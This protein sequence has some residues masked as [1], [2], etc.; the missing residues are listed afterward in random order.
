MNNQ[1][2]K[3]RKKGQYRKLKNIYIINN[4]VPDIKFIEIFKFIY[5]IGNKLIIS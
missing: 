2:S 3:D 4:F 1:K 5:S